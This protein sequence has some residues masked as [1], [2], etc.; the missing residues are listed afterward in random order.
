MSHDQNIDT[1]LDAL[2]TRADPSL[3]DLIKALSGASGPGRP[4]TEAE[5]NALPIL[6]QFR[7]GF[8]GAVK[9]CHDTG[10]V[11]DV[12]RSLQA[13]ASVA[14]A[15]HSLTLSDVHGGAANGDV[16]VTSDEGHSTVITW[17]SPASY[18]PGDTVQRVE[19]GA[20]DRND[21][22]RKTAC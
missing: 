8:N 4:Y 22:D 10:L 5:F 14:P 11:I 9:R 2:Q 15:G 16:R 17:T 20:I 13:F 3:A 12:V 21:G 1:G 18:K 7:L 6:Q 19:I